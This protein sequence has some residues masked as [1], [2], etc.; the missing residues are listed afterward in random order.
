MGNDTLEAMAASHYFTQFIHGG[1]GVLDKTLG[2]LA[3]GLINDE[4]LL[5]YESFSTLNLHPCYLDLLADPIGDTP[6]DDESKERARQLLAANQNNI[7]LC[8]ISEKPAEDL[9]STDYTICKRHGV[10]VTSFLTALQ[11]LALV[12]IFPPQDPSRTLAAPICVSN[13]LRHTV[14]RYNDRSAG[15]L[16]SLDQVHRIGAIM[17]P[18]M[19]S[20]ILVTPFLVS[21]YDGPNDGHSWRANVWKTQGPAAFGVLAQAVEAMKAGH[22]P[23][24]PGVYTPLSNAGLLDGV[25]LQESHSTIGKSKNKAP[26]TKLE[27]LSFYPR[28][29]NW[30]GPQTWA[31]TALGKLNIIMVTPDPRVRSVPNLKWWDLYNDKVVKFLDESVTVGDI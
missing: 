24:P 18:V 22:I 9:P 29:S 28:V 11:A 23:P 16:N 13:R 17:G 3:N 31:W 10:T 27:D 15:T 26:V 6:L 12:E 2:S 1:A 21:V 20:T 8:P 14:Y 25:H 19:A 5:S 7:T 30:F 4:P